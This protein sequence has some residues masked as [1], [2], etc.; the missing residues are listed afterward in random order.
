M[1]CKTLLSFIKILVVIVT[2]VLL[3]IVAVNFQSIM[4]G[5]SGQSVLA[6]HKVGVGEPVVRTQTLVAGFDI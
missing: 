3:K 6:R 1:L 2:T 4:T 5:R